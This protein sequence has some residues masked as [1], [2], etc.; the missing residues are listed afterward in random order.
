MDAVSA[1]ETRAVLRLRLE[2]GDR[3]I[4]QAQAAG[5]DIGALEDHWIR[6]LHEYE[7]TFTRDISR[8]QD[9]IEVPR[10]S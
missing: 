3:V 9:E 8:Q 7:Q 6:L 1:L 2:D 4:A 5:Q 10:A